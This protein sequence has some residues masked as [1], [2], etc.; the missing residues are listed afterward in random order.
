MHPT[1]VENGDVHQ[2]VGQFMEVGKMRADHGPTGKIGHAFGSITGLVPLLSFLNLAKL[3]NMMIA[4]LSERLADHA[5]RK[6]KSTFQRR[7]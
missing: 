3:A 7:Y 6:N 5:Q 2:Q 4:S 1:G